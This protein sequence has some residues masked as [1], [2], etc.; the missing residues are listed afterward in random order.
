MKTPLKRSYD[1]VIRLAEKAK[2]WGISPK[3]PLNKVLENLGDRVMLQEYYDS[4]K[5]E[6]L[7]IKEHKKNIYQKVKKF[8]TRKS[9][10]LRLLKTNLPE[11]EFTKLINCNSFPELDKFLDSL[12]RILLFQL[13]IRKPTEDGKYLTKNSPYKT[14]Y[15][16]WTS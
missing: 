15:T 1:K 9:V 8:K 3:P 10:C 4:I 2:L 13:G 6:I 11:C 14:K 7:F 12:P 5:L 16:G